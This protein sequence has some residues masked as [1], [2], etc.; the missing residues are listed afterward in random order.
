MK[1]VE[2]A[3][4]LTDWSE[5]EAIEKVA[6]EGRV[7]WRTQQFGCTRTYGR[8]LARVRFGPLVQEG[9]RAPVYRRRV[10]YRTR[11]RPDVQAD[12]WI[13]LPG[14]RQC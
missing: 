6:E 7:F 8:I 2:P 11:R 12:S 1:M 14:C 10:G 5:I 13:E 3:F 4:V 9:A